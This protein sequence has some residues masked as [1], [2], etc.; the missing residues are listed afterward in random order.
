[1][2]PRH[3]SLGHFR[4]ALIL[5]TFLSLQAWL[6]PH[7]ARPNYLLLLE[8]EV[9]VK[10]LDGPLALP[11]LPGALQRPGSPGGGAAGSQGGKV[12]ATDTLKGG[13]AVVGTLH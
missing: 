6:G 8:G 9:H 4:S 1:M 13:L 12:P 11:A 2:I 10:S 5:A 7:E 3:E